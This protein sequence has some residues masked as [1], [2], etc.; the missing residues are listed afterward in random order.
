MMLMALHT[1]IQTRAQEEIDQVLNQGELPSHNR[2]DHLTY[3]Q[4]ILKE[5]LRF[6]PVGPLC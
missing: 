5:V 4:A 2:L 6:A 3:L 1:S